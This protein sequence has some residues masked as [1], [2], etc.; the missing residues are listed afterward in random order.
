VWRSV[1]SKL[2]WFTTVTKWQ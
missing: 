1:V 2:I